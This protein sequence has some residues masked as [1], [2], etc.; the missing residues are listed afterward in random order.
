MAYFLYIFVGIE[1]LECKILLCKTGPMLPP[2]H[3]N[4][5]QV[6]SY[7]VKMLQN[8]LIFILMKAHLTL[9]NLT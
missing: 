1:L 8:K 4:W 9:A 2:G 3:R 7:L 6:S 5:Q